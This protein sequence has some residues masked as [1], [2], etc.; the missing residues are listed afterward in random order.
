MR[1][2]YRYELELKKILEENGFVVSRISG[3]GHEQSGDLIAIKDRTYLFEIKSTRQ[4]IF[5]PNV[6]SKAQL[7]EMAKMGR[8]ANLV[9]LLAIRY[10]K[11]GSILEKWKIYKDLE[12]DKYSLEEGIYIQEFLNTIKGE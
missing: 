1:K 4:R 5:Y 3:S 10:A 2:G 9:P 6:R 7:L 8:Q 11:G 12:K